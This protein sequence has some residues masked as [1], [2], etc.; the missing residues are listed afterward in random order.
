MS[1]GSWCSVPFTFSP[2]F[3]GDIKPELLPVTARH[4]QQLRVFRQAFFTFFPP[5]PEIVRRYI[6][7]HKVIT[8]NV[9]KYMYILQCV[10][11]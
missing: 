11:S 4:W 10:R 9:V 7:Y 2:L 6:F 1:S 3:V 5:L 8:K